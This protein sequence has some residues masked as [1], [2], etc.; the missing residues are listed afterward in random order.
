MF[1][2]EQL[3]A[4]VTDEMYHSPDSFQEIRL[5]P[6]PRQLRADW[7]D[8]FC[9]AWSRNHGL[10]HKIYPRNF[11]DVAPV[12]LDERHTP[13]TVRLGFTWREFSLCVLWAL[14][15]PNLQGGDESLRQEWLGIING[16]VKAEMLFHTQNAAISVID[17]ELTHE[18]TE[19][20]DS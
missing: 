11:V 14:G 18:E 5:D 20:K 9:R 16:Y 15:D 2:V 4:N 6:S 19:S 7:N 13:G 8:A 10:I 1:S 12:F 17:E 3:V